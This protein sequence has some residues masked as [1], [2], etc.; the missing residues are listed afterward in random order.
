[1][2]I[3]INFQL[4]PCRFLLRSDHGHRDF[5]HASLD[6]LRSRIHLRLM[7][8]HVSS[9][10]RLFD[11]RHRSVRP[12]FQTHSHGHH[13]VLDFR[14]RGRGIQRVAAGQNRVFRYV[15]ASL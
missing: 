4:L 3:L 1:M 2:K 5:R 10:R 8:Q 15:L 6:L 13:S 9:R 7:R 12:Y 11:G 14:A